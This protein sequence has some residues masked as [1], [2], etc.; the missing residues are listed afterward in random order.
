MKN[1]LKK[2]LTYLAYF[3]A[4][5]VIVLAV[6]VGIF[7]LMLPRLPEY[8]DEIK[9]WAGAAIGMQVDFSGMNA[10]WRL[11]G[12]ELNF[13][14]AELSYI[15]AD[16]SFLAA[17]E[18]SIGVGLLRLMADRELV[19]DRILIRETNIDL[20]QDDAGNWL[21]QGSAV[22]DLSGSRSPANDDD[23]EVEI[24][25]EDIH[26][27][28]E[29][30]GS[31][32]LVPFTITSMT[33]VQ[34][35]G[36]LGV[37]ATIDLPDAFGDSLEI[38]A[39]QLG[40]ASGESGWRLFVEGNSLDLSGWSRLQPVGMPEIESGTANVSVWLDYAG[41]AVQRASANLVVAELRPRAAATAAFG[42][43]GSIEYSSEPNGFLLAANRFRLLT[44]DGDWPESSL[45]LRV[46]NDDDGQLTGLRTN[47]SFLDLDDLKYVSVWM[48]E[49]QQATL[50]D[51]EP[52]GNLR[53]L[54]I[55]LNE[56][57]SELPQF[58]V[59]AELDEAG[60]AANAERPGMRRFS[61]TVRADRDGGRV[62]IESTDLLLDLGSLLAAPVSFDDALGTVIWRRNV[63]GVIV[64]SD[65]IRIRNADFDTQSSLQISIP[66]NGDAP[67]VDVESDWSIN[68]VRAVPRYLP[69]SLRNA[70]LGQWL[71]QA[72][73]AGVVSRGSLLLNG[74]LDNFPFD[75]GNGSFRVTADIDDLVLQYSD[76]WPAPEFRQVEIVVENMRLSTNRNQVAIV[77]NSLQN[78]RVV[79]PDL[80]TPVIEIEAFATGSLESLR[81]YGAA[82]P[83]DEILGGQLQRVNVSGEASV[84]LSVTYP[85]LD[86]SSYDFRAR[87][88]SSNGS[89]RIDGFPAPVSELNGVVTVTRDTIAAES[90]FGASWVTGWTSN[91]SASLIPCRRTACYSMPEAALPPRHCPTHSACR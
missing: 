27:T 50:A 29:H 56:I 14:D 65:S 84:D 52:S 12:P 81:A 78:A 59:I 19:V 30:P 5:M 88:Q 69:V 47:A 22:S 57:Q 37:T 41:G 89:V 40:D 17:E 72:P 54:G 80:R 1:I 55:D 11:S 39:D 48:P 23:G 21:V 45:M 71:Q 68:D 15:G 44:V 63:S 24:V 36:Q 35:E 74:S 34:D 77:G 4:A 87:I 67:F 38:S 18:V 76:R 61:G 43:R 83:I 28:Y 85:I 66:G 7:R 51:I 75:D 62:E 49:A 46:M 33:I 90:L 2:L 8:Q 79:I 42:V 86:K 32:Q 58:N 9:A 26:V 20:R 91:W 53:D 10:R 82:S 70:T 73:I 16:A 6:A 60:F 64:L 13:F 31:G 25:G 3:A